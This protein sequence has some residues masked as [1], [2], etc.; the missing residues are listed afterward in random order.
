MKISTIAIGDELLI[1]QV[2]DTNSGWI[3][4]EVAPYGWSLN[5]VKI[6]RDNAQEILNAI[7]RAFEVSD[8]VLTTG[9]LGPTKD[10]ITKETLRGYF[11]GEM[12]HNV[13]VERNINRIFAERN[14]KMNHL[15]AAQAIVPS[16]CEVINNRV[17]TAP[18]MWFEKDGKVLISMPGVPYEMRTV[19]REEVVGRLRERCYENQYIEHR[20]FVVIN[21]TE[22]LLAITLDKFEM[23]KPEYIKLAYL[24]KPGIVR[25]R[26]SGVSDNQG[27]LNA[28]MDRLS[29]QLTDILGKNIVSYG[30]RSIA[31]IVGE[32]LMKRNWSMATAESC[33][34][35]NIAHQITMVAGAS[36]YFRGSV[37]A[38]SNEVK[39]S[40][41]NVDADV[42]AK[43]GA[44]SAETVAQMAMGV[45]SAMDANC[46]IA[47]SGIAG[48]D[49]GTA[50]KP[51][52][53]VWVGIY[54]DGE[55]STELIMLKGDRES[56]IERTTTN[57]LLKLLRVLSE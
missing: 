40:M 17:G 18:V 23:E 52:G 54:C 24:P 38:Y 31:Q 27:A 21:Y 9:G 20:T 19:M 7:E 25:L 53:T 32:Q 13:E 41:L 49:G 33:T 4:R 57:T 10:D 12:I 36:N 44:V 3:A 14:I 1:G 34:G 56:I 47:T 11:G 26:L 16:S 51:V 37:V 22:S 2:T 50:E 42:L 8:V 43:Y 29:N 46:A 6:V 45:A 15:T 35:G 55:V 5:D 30:D 48:P 28:D 39:I